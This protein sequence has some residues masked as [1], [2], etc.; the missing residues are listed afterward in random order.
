MVFTRQIGPGRNCKKTRRT[1]YRSTCWKV[2][3][4][5]AGTIAV[6]FLGKMHE[7][8]PDKLL[9]NC[10]ETVK[11]LPEHC[12]TD[13]QT[14]A[15][16]MQGHCRKFA[17]NLIGNCRNNC[18]TQLQKQ[19]P[20][21]RHSSSVQRQ[22]FVGPSSVEPL[23]V[24]RR[25]SGVGP[26]SVLRRSSPCPASVWRRPGQNIFCGKPCRQNLI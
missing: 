18:R 8:L 20:V 4:Q 23:S 2:A 6:Q 10:R 1:N 3:G 11:N 9:N 24:I 12:Q 13:C 5:I 19:L 16:Q 15:R 7:Q 22:S 26:S 21:R 17:R 25:Q 14:I